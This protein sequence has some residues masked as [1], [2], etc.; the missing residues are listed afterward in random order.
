[1]KDVLRLFHFLM[2]TFLILISVL[3]SSKIE[4]SLLLRFSEVLCM[5]VVFQ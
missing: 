1:M 5:Y 3:S 2:L 4:N